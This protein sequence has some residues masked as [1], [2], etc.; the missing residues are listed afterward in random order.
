MC[1]VVCLLLLVFCVVFDTCMWL[2]G[3]VC[4]SLC[5]FVVCLSVCLCCVCLFGLRLGC[6]CVLCL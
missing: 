2:V 4:G 1:F 3:V 6:V 5:V